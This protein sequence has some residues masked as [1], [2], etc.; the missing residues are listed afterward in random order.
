MLYATRDGIRIRAK[1]KEKA[2]CPFCGGSVVAKCGSIVIWHWANEDNSE[3]DSWSH[4]ESDW[5]LWWKSLLPPEQVE[6]CIEKN[7]VKH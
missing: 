1:P 2:S 7:G 5:H 6:V 3:C 4:G